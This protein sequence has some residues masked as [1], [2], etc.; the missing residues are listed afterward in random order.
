MRGGLGRTL[1][2]AF[3]IL[4]ILPLVVIGGYAVRQNR[5]N[6]E[7][8]VASR[9]LAV[10]AV[11]GQTLSRWL[12]LLETSLSTVV[13]VEASRGV[14]DAEASG[15][16]TWWSAQQKQVLGL[17]GM[18][19]L[20]DAGAGASPSLLGASS[21]PLGASS[22]PL[23]AFTPAVLWQTGACRPSAEAMTPALPDL[24][25]AARKAQP[26]V[27]RQVV[28][29]DPATSGS[30][31][32][33]AVVVGA[34]EDAITNGGWRAAVL[35]VDAAA[36]QDVL[37]TGAGIGETGRVRLV[38]GSVVW[39]GGEPSI[40]PA[41][42]LASDLGD[43]GR[44]LGSYADQDG[45]QVVGAWYPLP[46]LGG[47]ILVE[48]S[49]AEISQST[50][51]IAA[52]LI[53]LILGVALGTTAI[54]AVVIRQITRPVI[55]LTESAV[56]MAE[57]D[58]DQHLSVRSRDEIGILTYVFNDMAAQ[59]KSLYEDLEAKVV[60]RTRRL[61]EANTQIQRRALHLQASQEVSQA[62]TS[63]R[64]PELLLMQV[65]DLIRN[66]FVYGAVAV[67]LVPPGGGEARLQAQPQT[68]APQT[69]TPGPPSPARERWGGGVAGDGSRRRQLG[70]CGD[71]CG[72]GR[73]P[74]TT[75]RH[76]A[77]TTGT[78]GCSAGRPSR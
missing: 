21:S 4:T 64:D 57:G 32:G 75:S 22:S 42:A 6:L 66:H 37:Q 60:E 10:A 15:Y 35:C 70:R 46:D 65:T 55:D 59:L 77:N 25:S 41:V 23:G 74:S 26:S 1:L 30:E 62:I 68:A 7:H 14:R 20:G 29:F 58:L 50:D 16:A 28:A 2:T 76:S 72:Q 49:Q 48:Q 45:T 63:I 34:A 40:M 33:L 17:T 31:A 71:L 47:G 19:V 69:A 5:M 36:V 43:G 61:Q 67:Y 51:S 53:A 27:S 52:T 8:E 3:L 12:D 44:P 9:L 13:L 73:P 56:A 78:P 18:V 24:I 38:H 39:P 11:K 54:A